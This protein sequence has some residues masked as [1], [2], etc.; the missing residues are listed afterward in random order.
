M[1]PSK[2]LLGALTLL[3]TSGGAEAARVQQNVPVTMRDGVK[4]M[5]D[6]YRPDADGTYPVLVLRTPYDRKSGSGRA[7]RS[8]TRGTSSSPR[9]YV[10]DT[11]PRVS[12]IRS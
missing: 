3:L 6:I 2:T 12:S 4:L 11:T 8:P 9:T 1:T 5:A 7:R 10:D